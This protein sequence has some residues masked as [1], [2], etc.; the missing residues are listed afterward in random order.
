M[1]IFKDSSYSR[2]YRTRAHNQF[3]PLFISSRGRYVWSE[4]GFKVWIDNGYLCFEGDSEFE[5][6]EGGESCTDKYLPDFKLG[7]VLFI[8]MAQSSALFPMMQFFLMPLK[9]P[10]KEAFEIVYDAYR[11]HIKFA[12]KIVKEVENAEKTG[13][14]I[15]RSLEYNHPSKRYATITDQF[16]LGEDI[17]VCPIDTKGVRKKE[18]VFP[19]GYWTDEKGRIYR[20]IRQFCLIHRLIA[21]FS[22]KK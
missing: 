22:S 8:K 3:M 20:G 19:K 13:E 4:A 2:D 5:L 12:H 11:L 6:Y 7:E 15:L 18:I 16:M 17:L 21:Y 1:P 10:S 9:H 14:P